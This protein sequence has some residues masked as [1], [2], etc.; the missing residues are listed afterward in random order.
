MSP[1]FRI[2]IILQTASLLLK[3]NLYLRFH[4][5]NKQK[6]YQYVVL[7]GEVHFRNL[8]AKLTWFPEVVIEILTQQGNQRIVLNLL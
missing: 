7:C 6:K 1:V 5:T 8:G 2:F 4:L 3:K